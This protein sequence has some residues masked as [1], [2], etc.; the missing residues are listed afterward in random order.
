MNNSLL[1]IHLKL[2]NL[3]TLEVCRI[4]FGLIFCYKIIFGFVRVN[5]EETFEQA[6]SRTGCRLFE[7]CKHYSSSTRSLFLLK[8]L[9][10]VETY[11]LIPWILAH[12]AVF[13]R[14]LAT[15]DIGLLTS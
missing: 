14:L 5:I 10:I 11:F 4:K 12:C 9:L 2:L 6:N 8:E 3:E 13:R 1:P 15:I 7:L